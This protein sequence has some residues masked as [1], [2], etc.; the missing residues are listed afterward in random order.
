[1]RQ[2]LP[3][4]VRLTWEWF[5]IAIVAGA[6]VGCLLPVQ[7]GEL[8]ERR[9]TAPPQSVPGLGYMPG[10]LIRPALFCAWATKPYLN[11]TGWRCPRT[12]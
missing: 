5:V 9:Y 2:V 11:D 6:L 3:V 8:P 12:M 7:H 4:R 1:M 10:E